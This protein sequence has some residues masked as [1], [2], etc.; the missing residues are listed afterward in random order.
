M[1]GRVI[2]SDDEFTH[3]GDGRLLGC[4]LGAVYYDPSEPGVLAFDLPAGAD[5]YHVDGSVRFVDRGIFEEF[6]KAN[7]ATASSS[8]SAPR[9][10]Q[11]SIF[12]D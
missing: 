10:E 8:S 4:V 5:V 1:P 12:I 3:P 7:N 11:V 2:Q 9:L 6:A